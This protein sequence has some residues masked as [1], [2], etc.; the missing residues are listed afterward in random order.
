MHDVLDHLPLFRT[1]DSEQDIFSSSSRAEKEG[2]HDCWEALPFF[3]LVI[4][5]YS[6]CACVHVCGG[7]SCSWLHG[8]V[9]SCIFLFTASFPRVPCPQCPSLLA[10]GGIDAHARAP[11][12][13][14]ALEGI[15]AQALLLCFRCLIHWIIS[16][17]QGLLNF[18]LAPF[19][20]HIFIGS[21]VYRYM[22]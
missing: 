16:L 12:T 5:F 11:C 1:P 9:H 3:S 8:I 22:K 7:I 14:W 21:Q 10:C 20:Q 2:W 4:V 18:L 6:V 13:V 17:A 19:P 15:W